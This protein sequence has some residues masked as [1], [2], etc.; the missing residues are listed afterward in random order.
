VS[1]A[2][3]TTGPSG[4]RI[5]PIRVPVRET[6]ETRG[7]VRPTKEAKQ[8]MNDGV[9]HYERPCVGLD[10]HKGTTT[11]TYLEAGG[12]TM[13]KW[14]FPTTR[15][16][17][18]ALAKQMGTSVPIVLE[19]STAGKAV[20][21]A[22]KEA[23]SEL[24]MAAP[25]K[26]ALIARAPVKTDERDSA[27]LAHLYQ[28]GFLPECYVPPPEIDRLRTLVRARSDLGIKATMAKN[29]AHAL[30]TRNL[31]DSE[32]KGVSDWFGV[33]GIRK[34]THL[35][36]PCGERAHLARYLEQ[37]HLL[38][39]QEESL[40]AELAKA[41]TERPDVQLLMTIPGVDY[42]TAVAIVAEIG[43]IRRFANKK[44]LCSLA[45]VVP[46]ADNSG[47][48][49]SSH[50]SVKKGDMV[51]KRFLCIAVQGML[52]ANQNTSIKRFYEK[53]S[54]SIGAP[55]AQV[56]A[57]RKLACAIWW[58]LSHGEPFRDQ[59]EDLTARKARRMETRAQEAPVEM[60]EE[61]LDQIGQKL[62]AKAPVLERLAR[63]AGN[64]G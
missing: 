4:S 47:E 20:A 34:L 61:E 28:A 49:V 32:M 50:R 41:A 5:D 59:D 19:A 45:G 12:K 10:V 29:Q 31:L 14:T 1:V 25:N 60:T 9:R 2:A 21:T 62:V 55:K 22:L 57:A 42:Y 27:A 53:K 33:A 51:L 64:A 26:I 56:A 46:R 39:E 37:L 15:P 6:V 17:L 44:Q 54:K 7:R 3:L 23:G 24:H 30:V 52:R 11:A 48:R 8:N 16:E 63:E 13:K 38:A 36:L 58:M 43:D 35:P 18:L 40:Q